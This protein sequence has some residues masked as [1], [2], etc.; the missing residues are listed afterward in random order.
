MP[1][2][3]VGFE[4]QL[5][6]VSPYGSPVGSPESRDAVR[7]ASRDDAVSQNDAVRAER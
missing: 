2:L 7:S 1:A 6:G 3:P 4:R 5:S